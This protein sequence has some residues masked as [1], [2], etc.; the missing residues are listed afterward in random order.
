MLRRGDQHTGGKP[1]RKVIRHLG[2]PVPKDQA[3]ERS[4]DPRVDSVENGNGQAT[5]ALQ[6]PGVSFQDLPG[7]VE[8]EPP[9]TTDSP[10]SSKIG[11]LARDLPVESAPSIAVPVQYAEAS[12]AIH[13][14]QADAANARLEVRLAKECAQIAEDARVAAEAKA[15]EASRELEAF[16]KAAQELQA[17]EEAEL[18]REAE[19]HAR[20]EAEEAE[21][22]HLE[23]V[24]AK[25]AAEAAEAQERRIRAEKA[26]TSKRLLA[27]VAAEAEEDMRALEEV[28][29]GRS[30]VRKWSSAPTAA[31]STPVTPVQSSHDVPLH[32]PPPV[33]VVAPLA[34]SVFNTPTQVVEDGLAGELH[35]EVFVPE[36]EGEDELVE[37]SP[38]PTSPS[39]PARPV[40]AKVAPMSSTS[41]TG[42][43]VRNVATKDTGSPVPRA[44]RRHVVTPKDL[45]EDLD[46]VDDPVSCEYKPVPVERKNSTGSDVEAL[47]KALSS[48]ATAFE[49]KTPRPER[50]R[51]QKTRG[52]IAVKIAG[53]V[54]G[55]L[56][57]L[58]RKLA[59]WANAHRRGACF[60]V[61]GALVII[62]IVKINSSPPPPLMSQAKAEQ[63][64]QPASWLSNTPPFNTV[65]KYRGVCQDISKNP[66]AVAT[67][68]AKAYNLFA[69]ASGGV[70]RQAILYSLALF[71]SGGDPRYVNSNFEGL[72]MKL[73]YSNP[74]GDEQKL[75]RE[76]G[77]VPLLGPR[78][79]E[80]SGKL[81][82][83]K[84][85][86]EAYKSAIKTPVPDAEASMLM[87][88]RVIN[89][90]YLTLAGDASK[91]KKL[92]N[93]TSDG[94]PA[95]S[96][97][98]IVPVDLGNSVSL[99]QVLKYVLR[100]S[101]RVTP[102]YI[103]R[104]T[105][106]VADWKK[107]TST[108]TSRA[109]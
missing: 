11:K 96:A 10:I 105:R 81:G 48:G 94:Q 85:Q 68:G 55:V 95:C 57:L 19:K 93:S 62:A 17:S 97:A 52:Q 75:E 77:L 45:D 66:G 28:H 67:T 2:P 90:S 65:T 38:A 22:W 30:S 46:P 21:M 16:R 27:T 8:P 4:S 107:P 12:G 25:S 56:G 54:L 1:K 72:R 82:L 39:V 9:P 73:L 99:C 26:L 20:R 70:N 34:D 24:M 79:N 58:I 32:I 76:V 5:Q 71:G 108:C 78:I 7:N 83:G 102:A 53:S 64:C 33:P 84:K 63:L 49:P 23:Q 40:L 42:R 88:A 18:L 43:V 36:W 74:K 60:A 13:Q 109:G 59:S 101:G 47:N 86:L 35:T 41:Q 104:V 69:D 100:D 92:Q 103:Q 91:R 3:A 31:I 15:S 14:A 37:P 44:A 50:P 98:G 51:S 89:E 87:A 106:C 80:V 29:S 61:A 6:A